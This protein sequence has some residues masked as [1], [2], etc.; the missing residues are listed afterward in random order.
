MPGEFLPA[1][2]RY[3]LISLLDRW[4]IRN[5][6]EWY[7]ESCPGCSA[8]ESVIMAINISGKVKEGE[9]CKDHKAPPAFDNP[10]YV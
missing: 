2:E 3:N 4:V 10:M 6:L 9:V 7:A 5:S 1:A 8:G